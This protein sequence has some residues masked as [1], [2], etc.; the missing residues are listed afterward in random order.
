MPAPIAIPDYETVA[1]SVTAQILGGAGGQADFISHIV[2]IPA[3]A[4][5]VGA[6]TLIDGAASIT[7]FAGGDLASVTPFSIPL[8]M[9]AKTGPWR[10]TTGANVSVIAVGNFQA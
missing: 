3:Q 2:V 9:Y 1:A 6:V 4:A 8:G 7:V 5:A 10:I